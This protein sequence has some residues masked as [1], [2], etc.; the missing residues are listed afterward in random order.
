LVQ[1]NG[2][3]SP[4]K[5]EELQQG[6]TILLRGNTLWRT[7]PCVVDIIQEP[8]PI[9]GIENTLHP[10]QP[11]C[12]LKITLT[13]GKYHQIRKMLIVAQSKVKRLIRISIENLELTDLPQGHIREYQQKQF[14]DLLGIENP[15]TIN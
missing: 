7:S 8:D 1:A 2:N 3:L 13:E 9:F 12:W 10:R 11:Y 6:V 4:E 5:I 14:F 15:D